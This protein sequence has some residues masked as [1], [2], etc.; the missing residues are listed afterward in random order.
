MKLI[1]HRI[2]DWKPGNIHGAYGAE[3]DVQ[4]CDD[5]R[6]RAKHNPSD[7][8]LPPIPIEEVIDHS[9]YERFFV[10]IKQNLDIYYLRKIV[11]AFGDKLIGLFDV[12]FPSSFYAYKDNLPIYSRVSEYELPYKMLGKVWLDPLESYNIHKYASLLIRA[13]YQAW[14]SIKTI[15]AC[16]SLHGKG[17]S[18]CVPVWRWASKQKEVFAIVTKHIGECRRI[19]NA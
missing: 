2:N 5:G 17:L 10:D 18:E 11:Y 14:D 3:I 9:G 8:Q 13:K 7:N 1:A 15:V 19:T 16:P 6:L 12:P 4:V